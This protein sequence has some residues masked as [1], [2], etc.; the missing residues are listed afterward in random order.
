[1]EVFGGFLLHDHQGFQF[2]GTHHDVVTKC[3]NGRVSILFRFS[4][5]STV[6]LQHVVDTLL[7]N[8]AVAADSKLP[9]RTQLLRP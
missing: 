4:L 9:Q 7:S 8:F 3:G 2:S 5:S 1:M 6:K